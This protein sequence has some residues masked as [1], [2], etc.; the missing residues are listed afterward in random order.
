MMSLNKVRFDIHGM[1]CAACVRRVEEGL[2]QMPGVQS[3]A[4]NF[5]TEKAMV[6]YDNSITSIEA[7]QSK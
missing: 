1:T 6:G 2:R 4:V 3:V 7:L 5:A